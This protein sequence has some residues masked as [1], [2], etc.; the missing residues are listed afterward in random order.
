MAIKTSMLAL[1]WVT[2][3]YA[4]AKVLR[5]KIMRGGTAR[6]IMPVFIMRW[7]GH[8]MPKNISGI[9]QSMMGIV[10][11]QVPSIRFRASLILRTSS[12][13]FPDAPSSSPPTPTI[14]YPASWTIRS[15]VSLSTFAGSNSTVAFSAAMLTLTERTPTAFFRAASTAAAQLAQL[16]PPIFRTARSLGCFTS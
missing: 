15:R 1:P 7:F 8:I 3:L 10:N 9:I 12:S 4:E 11:A 14:S 6:R 13:S 16:I 5:P 2:A